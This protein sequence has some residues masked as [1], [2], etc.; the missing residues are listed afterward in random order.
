[1]GGYGGGNEIEGRC[2]RRVANSKG[3]GKGLRH[4]KIN[5]YGNKSSGG[6]GIFEIADFLKESRGITEVRGIIHIRIESGEGL[7]G[8][9]TII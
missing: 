5:S 6:E 4:R 3:K 7:G 1:M 2:A 9:G 8:R